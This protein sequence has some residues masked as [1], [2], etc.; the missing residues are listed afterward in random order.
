MTHV[1]YKMVQELK[2]CTA[3]FVAL[4]SLNTGLDTFS[5]VVLLLNTQHM[6]KKLNPTLIF[7]MKTMSS[8]QHS[9]AAVS[10]I[11]PHEEGFGFKGSN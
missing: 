7:K 4:L 10:I 6:D 9:D 5:S 1:T 3:R 11:S 8:R 2:K